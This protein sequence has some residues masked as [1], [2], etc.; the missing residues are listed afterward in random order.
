MK[1]YFGR[2]RSETLDWLVRVWLHEGPPVCFLDGFPGVGK[3]DLA[4]ELLGQAE[5]QGK[6][7]HAVID[8]IGDRSRSVTE[9]LME[10]SSRLSRE[11]IREMEEVLW[12]Q[13]RP[14]LGHA[15]EKVLQRPVVIV[16][17][18]AQRL[19]VPD[20][21]DPLPELVGILD[22]LRN[23]RTLRGRLLLLSDR[24]VTKAKWSE[25]VH[26][27]TLKKRWRCSMPDLQKKRTVPVTF[28]RIESCGPCKFC[29]TI[30]GRSRR[31]WRE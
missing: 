24:D 23:R 12:L 8:E 26:K 15:F 17:D 19:L 11:G 16:M 27:R 25:W 21:G 7:E 22:Y 30:R 28:R 13:E 5:R 18:Q 14:M 29:T 3:T 20:R 31:W 4:L 9:N 1:K 2:G 6:W 10:F